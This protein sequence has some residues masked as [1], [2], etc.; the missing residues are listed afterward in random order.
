[1]NSSSVRVNGRVQA[2]PLV[3][4]GLGSQ[5]LSSSSI[6]E[7]PVASVDGLPSNPL[8]LGLPEDLAGRAASLIGLPL[9]IYVPDAAQE[10]GSEDAVWREPEPD[11]F[12]GPGLNIL[13]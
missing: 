8:G 10:E 5:A 7:S 13:A 2:Q 3:L 4:R 1:M 6:I 9:V 12:G 11:H